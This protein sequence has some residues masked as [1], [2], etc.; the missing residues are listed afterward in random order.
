MNRALFTTTA[1][2][3]LC[4]P[5]SLASA[6]GIVNTAGGD[7]GAGAETRTFMRGPTQQEQAYVEGL[8]GALEAPLAATNVVSV[9]FLAEP[10]SLTQASTPPGPNAY[11]T[12]RGLAVELE[13]LEVQ[14][15]RFRN[16]A[17]AQRYALYAV[18]TDRHPMSVEVRGRQVVVIHGEGLA[19]PE[20]ATELRAAAWDGLPA[21]EG[22]PSVAATY[23]DDD[24]FFI[25]NR[26]KDPELRRAIQGALEAAEE[27]QKAGVEG[28]EVDQSGARIRLPSG[29]QSE[30]AQDGA[31]QRIWAAPSSEE[32]A[33]VEAAADAFAEDSTE[34][35]EQAAE[36]AGKKPGKLKKPAKKPGKHKPKGKTPK[37]PQKPSGKKPGK[38]PGKKW[39]PKKVTSPSRSDTTAQRERRQLEG[40]LRGLR[41]RILESTDAEGPR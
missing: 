4:A 20:R 8:A 26:T 2:F 37:K 3:A 28:F 24:Q 21:P 17:E 16:P 36:Q 6:Q 34:L 22:P 35:A 23:L 29:F 10:P 5:F 14:R 40:N 41:Q 27:R 9:R 25:E 13:G 11:T 30:I 19:D 39:P 15:L 12:G 31:A 33:E 7:P 38:K 1:L 18:P 32:A